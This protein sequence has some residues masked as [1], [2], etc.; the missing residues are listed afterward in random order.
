MGYIII[1]GLFLIY[2]IYILRPSFTTWSNMN[3]VKH[4]EDMGVFVDENGKE[5]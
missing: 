1:I 3:Y 2:G 5:I 4:L